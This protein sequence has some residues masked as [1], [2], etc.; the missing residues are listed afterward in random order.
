MDTARLIRQR[1]S[2][3]NRELATE[4]LLGGLLGVLFTAV[5]LG[6]IFWT[7]WLI[8]FFPL[9][10]ARAT[11]VASVVAGVF[12]LVAFVSAW[13]RTNPLA[14][15]DPMSE[16]Q[17][18]RFMALQA[19]G[20]GAAAEPRRAL[21]GAAHVILGGPVNIL[22]AISTWRHRLRVNQATFAG[23][24]DLLNRAARGAVPTEQ[25]E[26]PP[27]ALLLNR[28][29][30]ARVAPAVPRSPALLLSLT[31]AGEQLARADG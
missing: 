29:G 30:L 20:Y 8:A 2:K 27:A 31:A 15:I 11:L 18:T 21:A 10:S 9:G 24:A 5:V 13:R 22:E 23:A 14:G 3:R 12:A 28:L 25:I 1:V 19:A 17:W 26:H 6:F 16:A 7:A 4:A